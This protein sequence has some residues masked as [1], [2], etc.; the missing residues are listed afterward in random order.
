MAEVDLERVAV[1]L[2]G[3][4]LAVAGVLFRPL[5]Q[6]EWGPYVFIFLL[7]L[8]TS[9][10]CGWGGKGKP[11]SLSFGLVVGAGAA[12]VMLVTLFTNPYLAIG[13][14]AGLVHIGFKSGFFDRRAEQL[15]SNQD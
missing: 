9:I 3:A 11:Y 10:A 4:M 12:I 14:G 15:K 7:W 13:V 8:S 6:S 2:I 1:I 5:W